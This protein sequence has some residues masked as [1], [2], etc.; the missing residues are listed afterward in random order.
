MAGATV[1]G[2]LLALCALSV[3]LLSAASSRFE[4]ATEES[5]LEST[6][7]TA[8]LRDV[9][10]LE[11]LGRRSLD[12]GAPVASAIELTVDR[13][14]SNL[15]R[16]ARFDAAAERRSAH[17]AAT[18]FARARE[19]LVLGSEAAFVAGVNEVT[20]ATIEIIED[21]RELQAE[22]VRMRDEKR[23][24]SL[25]LSRRGLEPRTRR[26]RGPPS[27]A[28][29]GDSL[30]QPGPVA[31]KQP[32]RGAAPRPHDGLTGVGNRDLLA[33]RY[34]HALARAQRGGSP[35]S[36]LF[37]DLDAFKSVNDS[38][39]YARGDELLKSVAGRL[40]GCVRSVETVARVGGDEFALLVE[41]AEGQNRST[42]SATIAERVLESIAVPFE[43][44]GRTLSMT[45]SIGIAHARANQA[46]DQL[47]RDGD[48]AMYASKACGPGGYRYFHP[49][50]P[51]AGRRPARADSRAA[52]GSCGREL[53]CA[54]P[55][56]LRSADRSARRG[57]GARPLGAPRARRGGPG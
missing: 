3:V 19:D 13:I 53:Q 57:R 43:V 31:G 33:E 51:A 32:R 50:P 29:T 38:L 40:Q 44:A 15:A 34:G 16:A 39:G 21:D 28:A 2:P 42:G 18:A 37:V 46:I 5:R 11:V 55:A 26:I 6:A 12:T 4:G 24:E 8:L 27:G 47:L 9:E 23:R 14:E 48:S 54:L 45:V 7:S 35:P 41:W 22:L 52:S 49:K 36:L 20:G 17:E 25:L 56:D 30:Q 10:T 1:V